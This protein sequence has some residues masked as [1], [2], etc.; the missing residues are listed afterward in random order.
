VLGD[1]R[2]LIIVA[3]K[4]QEVSHREGR[5]LLSWQGLWRMTGRG[6][7]G[8]LINLYW[9]RDL[10]FFSRDQADEEGVVTLSSIFL[11]GNRNFTK[12]TIRG[13]ISTDVCLERTWD[14]GEVWQEK[15]SLFKSG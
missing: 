8:L 1:S 5:G 6:F 3:K 11:R 13:R 12:Q 15:E 4:E 14:L 9:V 7:P 10:C 2:D